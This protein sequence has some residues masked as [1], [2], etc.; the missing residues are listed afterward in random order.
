MCAAHTDTLHL[1]THQHLLYE[2][3]CHDAL[4]TW[5]RRC[6][7]CVGAWTHHPAAFICMLY[8]VQALSD[9][10]GEDYVPLGAATR[11]SVR[12][13]GRGGGLP[14]RTGGYDGA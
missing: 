2:C 8:G 6:L 14:V 3:P 5:V 7:W 4:W 10:E 1:D 9:L 12:A 13:W 11:D